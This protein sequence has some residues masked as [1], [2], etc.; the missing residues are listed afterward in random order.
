MV[1]F[2]STDWPPLEVELL[3]DVKCDLLEYDGMDVVVI[4]VVSDFVPLEVKVEL[5]VAVTDSIA[6]VMPYDLGFVA[7]AVAASCDHADSLAAHSSATAL[8]SSASP[9]SMHRHSTPAT[10]AADATVESVAVAANN[11]TDIMQPLK[12]STTAAC[13]SAQV[14][15]LAGAAVVV[16]IAVIVV[17]VN[18]SLEGKVSLAEGS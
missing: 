3:F 8:S 2:L 10:S 13:A 18:E 12:L 9:G 7:V 4:V 6:K 14:A 17:A 11:D 15:G 1:F 16:A 5:L